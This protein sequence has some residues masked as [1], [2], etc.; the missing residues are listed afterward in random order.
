MIE[1]DAKRSLKRDTRYTVKVT[2]GVNDEGN[3]LEAP[4]AWSFK[5][6]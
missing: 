3:N 4:T 1:L 6:K 5:T 2:A